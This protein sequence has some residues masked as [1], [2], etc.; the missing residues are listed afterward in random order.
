MP[1]SDRLGVAS[2]TTT[3]VAQT[4][5]IGPPPRTIG[6]ITRLSGLVA[7]L[8]AATGC[9]DASTDEQPVVADVS[10]GADPTIFGGAR[11]DD[12]DS[13]SGVVAVR[14]GSGGSFELCTGALIAPNVVLSARHCVTKNEGTAVSCDENGQS[15]NG[16][17]VVAD[18]DP[19]TI[20]V[21][22][23]AAPNFGTKPHAVGRAVV[24]PKSDYL[25]DA[26]IALI[27][28][29]REVVGVEPMPVRV[30][31]P[32]DSGEL[33]RSVGYGQNDSRVP[34]GTRFRKDD[35]QVL[36]MGKGVSP[37]KTPLGPH[38]FEVGRS[39]CQGDSGGPAVSE[40]T[41]AVVGV[42]SRGGS[43]S[44]DYGHIYTTTAGFD[45]LFKEAFA[46]AGGAP[47]AESSTGGRTRQSA[48]PGL[49]SGPEPEPE[50]S[51]SS[52][53]STGR[54]ARLGSGRVANGGAGLFAVALTA[55]A[56]AHRRSSRRTGARSKTQEDQPRSR[57]GV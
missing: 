30:R 5:Y 34:I 24:A 17:H 26:D 6:W 8:L 11:D 36:A 53:S 38:E 13:S 37:S 32:V 4:T 56:L 46:I 52:C 44:D 12:R 19:A 45:A 51:S 7:A 48:V 15:A 49:A 9:G 33:I 23:G 35:V 28:L 29:D 2:P 55:A 1:A 25:C 27:V 20:G 31:A 57:R 10:T 14:V 22:V 47:M 54:V 39:I 43:C 41:G 42:V 40:R 50:A 21:F 18:E 16:K 3:Q